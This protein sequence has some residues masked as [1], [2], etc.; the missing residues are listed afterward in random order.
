VEP[1][2]PDHLTLANKKEHRI[3]NQY[4]AEPSH[5]DHLTLANKK[6]HRIL[7]QY[8]VEPSHPDHLTLANKKEHR[9][10]NQYV[11]DKFNQGQHSMGDMEDHLN[12][13]NHT[14]EP[15]QSEDMSLEHINKNYLKT[16]Y[17]EGRVNSKCHA[18]ENSKEMDAF[19]GF[20]ADDSYHS[21]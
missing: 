1:S 3:L 16:D 8:V 13:D 12:H 11:V 18:V 2:H 15:I 5:P 20:A 17:V 6:E 7:N 14:E 9:I 4:V 21:A 19:N 10:L